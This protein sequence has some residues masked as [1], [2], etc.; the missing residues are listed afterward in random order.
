MDIA[1]FH[2]RD[3]FKTFLPVAIGLS[4]ESGNDICGDVHILV[5]AAGICYESL[6]G[7]SFAAP[8][9]SAQDPVTAALEREV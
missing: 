5:R 6:V 9:H 3:E 7:G 4:W 1:K 8:P 2:S